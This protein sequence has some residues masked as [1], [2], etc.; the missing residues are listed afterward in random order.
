VP[1]PHKGGITERY[2]ITVVLDL[3]SWNRELLNSGL[4]PRDDALGNR[5]R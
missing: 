4:E 5:D 2:Y 1:P 3:N